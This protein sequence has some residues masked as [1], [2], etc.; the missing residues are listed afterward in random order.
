MG[1]I[2]IWGFKAAIPINI[3]QLQY[4]NRLAIYVTVHYKLAF[5][6]RG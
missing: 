2:V 4:V 5:I 1:R 3:M 6:L